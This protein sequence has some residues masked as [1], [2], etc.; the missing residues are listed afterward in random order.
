[1]NDAL[2]TIGKVYKIGVKATGE[3][4]FPDITTYWSRHS[5]ASLAAEADI[6]METI[7]YAMGHSTGFTTTEIYVNYSQRKIDEAN[8]KVIDLLNA[9]LTPPK[10]ERQQEYPM[11]GWSSNYTYIYT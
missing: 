7:A 9:D 1:M 2:K 10:E 5:W 4:L 8:R 3:P 11:W 6:P